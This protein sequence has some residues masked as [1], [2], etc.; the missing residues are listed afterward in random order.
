M[1]KEAADSFAKEVEE[2]LGSDY[3]FID[4]LKYQMNI[5]MLAPKGL[6]EYN[7]RNDFIERRH[8]QVD[9]PKKEKKT[10]RQ[11]T[12]DMAAENNCSFSRMFGIVRD[13]YNA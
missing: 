7:L 3:D 10:N 4:L 1:Y 13:S 5:G 2:N 6:C 11:L 9:L 8:A 12:D